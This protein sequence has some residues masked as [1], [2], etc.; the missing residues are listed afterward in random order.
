MIKAFREDSFVSTLSKF[1]PYLSPIPTAFFIVR[2]SLLYLNV[3]IWIALIIGA[4][5]ELLGL[6]SIYVCIWQIRY[7]ST[8]RQKD[9][10]AP[11]WLSAMSVI[12]YFVSVILLTTVLEFFPASAKFATI[13]FPILSIIGGFNLSLISFQL[14]RERG[15]II[16]K[17]E[18]KNRVKVDISSLDLANEA[19]ILKKDN[20]ISR[21]E[22]EMKNGNTSPTSLAHKFGRSRTTIYSYIDEINAKNNHHEK[23]IS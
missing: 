12:F 18:R 4:V 19:R 7:N 9:E 5:V 3:P 21:I 14:Q 23:I 11:I 15:I 1:S 10:K 6:S 2:S 16:E 22:S 8:K 20:I 13:I 17:E